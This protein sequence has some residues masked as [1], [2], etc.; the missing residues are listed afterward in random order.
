MRLYPKDCPDES[1]G[2]CWRAAA[3]ADPR[4][5]FTARRVR[6]SCSVGHRLVFEDRLEFRWVVLNAAL[7]RA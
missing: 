4:A 1:A 3:S 2:R 6:M 5:N 7:K